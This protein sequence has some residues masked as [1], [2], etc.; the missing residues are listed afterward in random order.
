MEDAGW[1]G[2]HTQAWPV[3]RC[4]PAPMP[5]HPPLCPAGAARAGPAG[6]AVPRP[7]RPGR[8]HP[9]PAGQHHARCPPHKHGHVSEP[10]GG[11]GWVGGAGWQQRA[12]AA[13]R[14][15][16]TSR[17]G[18]RVAPARFRHRCC[19]HAL[20]LGLACVCHTYPPPCALSPP[21]PP[22]P[23]SFL[24]GLF[25]LAMDPSTA[26]RKAVCMGLVAMLLAVP[27]RLEPSMPDLIEYMLKATQ[28]GGAGA[29]GGAGLGCPS[30]LPWHPTTYPPD[31]TR[32]RASRWRPASF[33]PPFVRARRTRT[34]CAPSC[35]AWC[36]CC[37]K[38]WWVGGWAW[39]PG[40]RQ[41]GAVWARWNVAPRWEALRRSVAEV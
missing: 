34:C 21:P 5:A 40:R 17:E 20:L 22:P 39:G 14:H 25:T 18:S 15:A 1:H 9:Q 28:V 12:A 4:L 38:T 8:V 16:R 36:R 31:R 26:V 24:Q 30:L 10:W 23:H 32:T 19:V 6:R 29:Q 3:T 7:P 41:G 2:M 13:L 35:P 37:S 11:L 27:D 33:G